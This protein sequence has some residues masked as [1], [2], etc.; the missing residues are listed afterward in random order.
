MS[1]N[2]IKSPYPT[3]GAALYDP[4]TDGATHWVHADDSAFSGFSDG[5]L[6]TSWTERGSVGTPWNINSGSGGEPLYKT[7]G[8][9]GKPYIRFRS[10]AG[11][12]LIGGET[13]NMVAPGGAGWSCIWVVR[14]QQNGS[15]SGDWGDLHLWGDGDDRFN[16]SFEGANK[17]EISAYSGP[18]VTRW[19]SA[20]SLNTWYIVATWG[21]NG[22]GTGWI[23]V[24]GGTAVSGNLNSSLSVHNA[25]YGAGHDVDFAEGIAF[26]TN[27]GETFMLNYVAALNANYTVF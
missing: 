13:T 19:G 21:V 26:N 25:N 11:R 12:R 6:V 3:A 22:T 5:D 9:N 18:G 8:P 20:A 1:A 15:G 10:T 16:F 27:K 14:P 24:N 4:V 2:I 23:S 7:G 17:F